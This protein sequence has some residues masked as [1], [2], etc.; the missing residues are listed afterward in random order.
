LKL[1]DLDLHTEYYYLKHP[2]IVQK[3]HFN[4]RTF[5]AKFQKITEPLTPLLVK[6][7]LSRAYT[8]AT[9][10]V[11]N[12]SVHYMYIEY[13][14]EEVDRF[15][16]LIAHLFKRESIKEYTIYEGKN[17][18]RIQ[19]F[20]KAHSITLEEAEAFLTN[21]S[22]KMK[23]HIAFGWKCLPSTSLPPDY[24]IATLPYKQITDP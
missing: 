18:K 5:Y 16:H 4:Q 12:N 6:Q 17:E 9:P 7:H 11:V 13:R 10:L 24:N 14:G 8:L 23:K 20:I 1:F 15:Y 3:I 2:K 22:H 21:L 19:I